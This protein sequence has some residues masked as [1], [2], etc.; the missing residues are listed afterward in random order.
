MQ[1]QFTETRPR[2]QK[3]ILEEKAQGDIRHAKYSKIGQ[4]NDFSVAMA[5]IYEL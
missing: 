1:R 5:Y 3:L 4:I 2:K